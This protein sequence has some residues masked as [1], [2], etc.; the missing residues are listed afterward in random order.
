[1][2]LPMRYQAV[3]AVPAWMTVAIPAPGYRD[4]SAGRS[5]DMPA[6]RRRR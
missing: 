1:M 6:S 5:R 3:L 4:G 2:T